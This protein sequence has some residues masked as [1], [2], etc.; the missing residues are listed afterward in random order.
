MAQIRS[1][2]LKLT[3]NLWIPPL[4]DVVCTL[5][6]ST[7]ISSP[8]K[9]LGTFCLWGFFRI[10]GKKPL[11]QPSKP[12]IFE[13]IILQVVFCAISLFFF[14]F[15]PQRQVRDCGEAVPWEDRLFPPGAQLL[16]VWKSKGI[17]PIPFVGRARLQRAL[18]E[19][20][21]SW[22]ELA[23]EGFGWSKSGFW[24][25]LYT[26]SPVQSCRQLWDARRGW[27]Q[28]N[29]QPRLGIWFEWGDKNPKGQLYGPATD[30]VA[31][32][33]LI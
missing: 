13:N 11:G 29:E 8:F 7:F 32:Q 20:S 28:L 21:I 24:S 9:P 33:G 3:V 30:K 10:G 14:F 26:L 22:K 6:G 27:D 31:E 12:L 23:S 19:I 5:L 25:C 15:L 2:S 1:L 16:K 18:S 4:L 17:F